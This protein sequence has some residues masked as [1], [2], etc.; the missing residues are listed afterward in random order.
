MSRKLSTMFSRL[1]AVLKY[2]GALVLPMQRR[3]AEKI[4]PAAMKGMAMV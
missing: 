1:A 2:S 3:M 4:C